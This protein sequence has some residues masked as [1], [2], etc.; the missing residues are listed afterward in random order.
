M[1]TDTYCMGLRAEAMRVLFRRCFKLIDFPPYPV[2]A[3]Q[4]LAA[5]EVGIRG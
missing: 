5:G 4:L 1:P 3:G 2:E